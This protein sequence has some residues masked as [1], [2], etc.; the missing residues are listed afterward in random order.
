M[1]EADLESVKGQLCDLKVGSYTEVHLFYT[2]FHYS[3][4]M[5]NLYFS[6]YVC[7]YHINH[8]T[9]DVAQT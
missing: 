6:I 2:C 3:S 5:R 4:Y 7:S 1:V 8:I 9:P